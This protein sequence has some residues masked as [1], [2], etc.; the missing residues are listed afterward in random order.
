MRLQCRCHPWNLHRTTSSLLFLWYT[1]DTIS[2]TRCKAQ[3]Q[4][5]GLFQSCTNSQHSNLQC[6][7]LR[8]HT[9]NMEDGVYLWYI[10]VTGNL[11]WFVGPLPVLSFATPCAPI[12]RL[13]DPPNFWS[14][15]GSSRQD[16]NS[17]YGTDEDDGLGLGRRWTSFR[18]FLR[19]RPW[20]RTEPSPR[21]PCAHRNISETSQ[22]N[23]GPTETHL[24]HRSETH[25]KTIGGKADPGGRAHFLQLIVRFATMC[26]YIS[27]IWQYICTMWWYICTMWR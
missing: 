24:K 15:I 5:L 17:H 4:L 19:S 18:S 3:D 16:K 27:T 12:T 2:C 13:S 20:C 7:K 26:P 14:E 6:T 25:P 21:Q 10:P 1:P 8:L 23:R 9:D 11:G 22:N